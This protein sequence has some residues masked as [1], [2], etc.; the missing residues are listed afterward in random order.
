[1]VVVCHMGELVNAESAVIIMG[2]RPGLG[3]SS[4]SAY[5]AYRPTT[6]TTAADMT[7]LSNINDKGVV[8]AEAGRQIAA[9]VE[10]VLREQKAG[11]ELG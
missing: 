11:V 2:E 9:L 8:P 6:K 5:I 1:M 4:L 7:V 10:K 3:T